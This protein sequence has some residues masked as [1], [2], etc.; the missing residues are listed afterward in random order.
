M[1]N[2]IF[3]LSHYL[4]NPKAVGAVSE[5]S[6]RVAKQLLKYVANRPH[7]GPSKILEV[8]AGTGSITRPLVDLLHKGDILD[9]V[10]I[11]SACCKKLAELFKNDKRVRVH[12]ASITEF[13]PGYQYD[14]I[15]STLPFNTFPSDFVQKVVSLY[16]TIIKDDGM[17]AYVEY[18][19]LQRIN[20]LFSKKHEKQAIVSRKN[21]LREYHKKYL[22]EKNDVFTNFLPCHV[23][24]MQLGKRESRYLE[25]L[26]N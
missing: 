17:C 18:M 24:H 7:K 10:E 6:P 25:A 12:N 14:F 13:D 5:L 11:D 16:K 22:V 9:I 2:F 21:L 4:R 19:G 15:I 20:L 3:F 8:G 23:Y 1:G 26:K